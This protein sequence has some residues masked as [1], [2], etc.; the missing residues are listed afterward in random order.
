T[1]R[2][3]DQAASTSLNGQAIAVRKLRFDGTVDWEIAGFLISRQ[4]SGLVVGHPQGTPVLVNGRPG[5]HVRSNP[6]LHFLWTDRY[7]SIYDTCE[8]HGRRHWYGNVQTPVCFRG[9]VISYI[10]L[11]LDIVKER[12]QAPKLVDVDEF[13][14]QSRALSYPCE[15]IDRAWDAAG[16]LLRLLS[17]DRPALQW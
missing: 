16:H 10:D 9:D 11:D 7:Y 8:P 4:K 13:L 17:T 14:K 3:G 15:V 6:L 5:W 1:P 12:G 2:G